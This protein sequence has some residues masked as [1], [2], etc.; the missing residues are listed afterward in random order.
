MPSCTIMT[1]QFFIISPLSLLSSVHS[2]S[3]LPRDKAPPAD[4]KIF[5]RTLTGL[6][7]SAHSSLVSAEQPQNIKVAMSVNIESKIF[8][9]FFTLLYLRRIRAYSISLHAG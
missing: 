3:P 4:A 9:I 1:K 5:M 2:S 6:L 7:S 8:F